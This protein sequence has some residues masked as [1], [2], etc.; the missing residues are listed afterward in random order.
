MPFNLTQRK[1]LSEVIRMC[2]DEILENVRSAPFLVAT[3][4]PAL[5]N[6]MKSLEYLK[7]EKTQIE[8]ALATIDIPTNIKN[9]WKNILDQ[10][11]NSVSKGF[12]IPTKDL[13]ELRKY[14]N[15]DPFKMAEMIRWTE[16]LRGNGAYYYFFV[17][18]QRNT[19]EGNRTTD[20]IARI[21]FRNDAPTRISIRRSIHEI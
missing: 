11:Q 12:G 1:T 8:N 21:I 4:E 17:T 14:P 10:L 3:V 9:I 18:F 5:P 2:A 15:Y 6:E 19:G 7:A 20:S 16:L 13:N